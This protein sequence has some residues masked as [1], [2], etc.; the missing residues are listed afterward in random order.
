MTNL[1]TD[2][3]SPYHAVTKPAFEKDPWDHDYYDF[4]DIVDEE[5][6][7]KDTISNRPDDPPENSWYLA[8]DE[9]ILYIY[10]GETWNIIGGTDIQESSDID[11]DSTSGGTSGN[12]HADSASISD[13]DSKADD[14]HGN[15]AHTTDYTD[16]TPSDVTSSNWD[17]YEIQKDGSD[18]DGVI[19]FKT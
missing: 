14:P 8:T 17:D 11:H 5:L 4:I 15:E 1:D 6:V 12:P 7:K 13:L 3:D 16:T 9:S 19:N 2:E 10:D 18:T